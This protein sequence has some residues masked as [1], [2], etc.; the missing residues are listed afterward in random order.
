MNKIIYD[1]KYHYIK[2]LG[3]GG[4][5]RVFLAKEDVSGVL[6]AI[7]E[8]NNKDISA[9]K[10][11]IKEIKQIAEF[12]HEGIVRYITNFKQDGLLYLVMEYCE[13]GNLYNRNKVNVL[14]STEIIDFTIQIARTLAK[15]HKMNIVHHDIKPANILVTKDNKVKIADFG[16]V[17]TMGGTRPYMGPESLVYNYKIVADP[18]VDIYSLGV[19]LMELLTHKNPF[20]GK[21]HNEIIEIHDTKNFPIKNLPQWQQEIILKAINKIP[22]LRF[23][24]M[25]DFAE[26]LEIRQVPLF[27]NRELLEAGEFA[28]K[29]DRMLVSKKW[30]RVGK[31]IHLA[32]EKYPNVVDILKITGKYYLLQ[33]K[34]SIAKK[35]YDKALSLNPRLEIQKE[36]AEINI[37]LKNFPIAISLI[38]DHLHRH[39]A[40]YEAYNLLL[41]CYYET[42]R[43]EAGIEL[44]KIVL[45]GKADDPILTNNYYLC[46]IM[47]SMPDAF[48]APTVYKARDNPFIDYNMSI[49]Y[50]DENK[51][52][53][54]YNNQ[55][56]LKSK[57]LFA[58][59]RFSK[60]QSSKL[61]FNTD[62]PGVYLS[63]YKNFIIKFGRQGYTDNTIEVPGNT[64]I[65][66]RHCLIL[67]S[68]DDV[69][70]YDLGSTG[71]YL[72]GELVNRKAQLIGMSNIQIHDSVYLITT[73]NNKLL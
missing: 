58:D 47:Q 43:Y 40:D 49:C 15:V 3:V 18:R 33:N 36:L 70:L 60:L 20:F 28:D 9:Q 73:D 17:N 66:R 69:W 16:L 61:F 4:F 37:S 54:N 31:Y 71:T 1:K 14:R 39:P 53:H 29:L 48:V 10:D 44:G 45:R 26:A 50:E 67:N 27:L 56:T 19:T 22:E 38:S 30:A 55:P 23:Q 51:L 5:G 24:T 57:L 64:A 72:N 21:S 11:I 35:Y 7:K 68:K 46:H 13:Q 2:D 65:S 59:Y 63:E 12:N 52:S 8:L 62:A 25:E 42:D 6:V 34:V 32:C 41:Q